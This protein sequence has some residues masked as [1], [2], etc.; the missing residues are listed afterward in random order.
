MRLGKGYITTVLLAILVVMLPAPKAFADSPITSTAF[1]QAYMDEPMVAA[2]DEAGQVTQEL[3]AY[4]ADQDAPLD[5]RAAVINAIGWEAEGSGRVESYARFT[6]G[7]SFSEIDVTLLRGDELFVIGYLL[8]M[9]DYIETTASEE[10]LLGAKRTMPESFTAAMIH[11]LVVSQRQMLSGGDW[12]QSWRTS[13]TVAFDDRLEL[14]MRL[15]AAKIIFDYMRLYHGGPVIH[16][17]AGEQR[18]VLRVGDP[19]LTLNGVRWENDAGMNMAVLRDGRVYVPVRYLAEMV[20]GDVQWNHETKQAQMTVAGTRLEWKI[21][22]SKALMNGEEVVLDGAPFLMGSRT[23]MPVRLICEAL[24]F[25][26]DWEGQS[27]EILLS[28]V[29]GR[30]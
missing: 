1:F 26:V 7:E 28:F 13:A 3:A 4:L 19:S 24:G 25:D 14:D 12:E 16:P 29:G 9:D 6:Y 18:L 15:D 10:L 22:D 30:Q 8:A 23:M 20:G 27:E 2:A 11:A 17:F 21:G 5:R